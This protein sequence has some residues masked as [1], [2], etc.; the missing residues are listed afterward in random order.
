MHKVNERQLA[1]VKILKT[2]KFVKVRELNEKLGVTR[3]TIRYDLS[4][5]RRVCPDNII[6]HSGRYTGGIEW[7][8]R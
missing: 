8:D 4:Y 5:L 3:R 6:S 1:I 7:V 2:E